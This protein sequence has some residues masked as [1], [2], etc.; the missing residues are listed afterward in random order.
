MSP[1]DL[2]KVMENNHNILIIDVREKREYESGHIPG[3]VHVPLRQLERLKKEADQQE[4]GG[5]VYIYC[6]SG[7]R[8]AIAVRELRKLGYRNVYFL[9]GGLINWNGPV[10]KAEEKTDE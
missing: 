6:R 2:K 5:G 10:Q 3:A 1:D 4:N 7:S 8:S 9:R